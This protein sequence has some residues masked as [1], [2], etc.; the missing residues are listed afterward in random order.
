MENI[1]PPF[2]GDTIVAFTGYLWGAG[3]VSFQTLAISILA[4]NLAGALLMYFFGLEVMNFFLKHLKSERLK[5][6]FDKE[7]LD[8]THKWFNKYGFFAVMFSRFSAGIRFFVSIVAGMANMHVSVFILAFLLATG[9]WNSLLIY[10]GYV[11][12]ENWREILQYIQVYSAVFAVVLIAFAY[13]FYH[14]FKKSK[15]DSNE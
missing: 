5:K 10:G 2:P 1:F 7:H 11:M 15:I 8:K 6:L 4:G 13:Y 12:G 3:L 14:R 9:L